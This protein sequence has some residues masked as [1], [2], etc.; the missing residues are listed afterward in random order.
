MQLT[1]PRPRPRRF[2][3]AVC[4]YPS[5]WASSRHSTG[6]LRRSRYTAASLGVENRAAGELVLHTMR[7]GNATGRQ[8]RK[9][10]QDPLDLPHGLGSRAFLPVSLF[11]PFKINIT[12]FGIN[13]GIRGIYCRASFSNIVV[14]GTNTPLFGSSQQLAVFTNGLK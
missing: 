6:I 13:L 12:I 8:K 5:T 2:V 10:I 7:A 4:R 9:L 3:S 11:G 14:F 1:P